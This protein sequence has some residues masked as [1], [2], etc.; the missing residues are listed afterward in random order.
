ML[1][2]LATFWNTNNACCP[3]I[4]MCLLSHDVL[5]QAVKWGRD[6]HLQGS[7]ALKGHLQRVHRHVGEG[8][9]G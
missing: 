7:A 5:S 1:L 9:Q 4:S 6:I 3:C 8:G 2:G